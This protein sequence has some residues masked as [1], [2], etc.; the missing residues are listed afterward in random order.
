M[1]VKR[2][3]SRQLP[4]AHPSLFDSNLTDLVLGGTMI[5][6]PRSQLSDRT[7]HADLSH[8]LTPDPAASRMARQSIMK[9]FRYTSI[10]PCA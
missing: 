6:L 8:S 5:G 4:Y 9:L 3:A 7:W 10:S 1:I 2:E